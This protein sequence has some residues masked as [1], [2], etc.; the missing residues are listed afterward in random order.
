MAILTR[1]RLLSPTL[2]H[3]EIARC[4]AQEEEDH[5]APC[6]GEIKLLITM[7]L[8]DDDEGIDG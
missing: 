7:Y 1:Q 5:Q 3:R 6:V 2:D 4:K 8:A